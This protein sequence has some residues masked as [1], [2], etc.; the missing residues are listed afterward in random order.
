MLPSPVSSARR[1]TYRRNAATSRRK[2]NLFDVLYSRARVTNLGFL[3][4]AVV[5]TISLLYN[6]RYL[7][8]ARQPKHTDSSVLLSTVSR[9]VTHLRLNHL[10]I[11][12]GHAIWKGTDPELRLREDQWVLEP[13]QRGGGRISTFFAHIYRGA[14]LVR[15]DVNALLVFSGGQTRSASTTTEAE[16]YMRLALAADV[17]QTGSSTFKR[18]TTEDHALDSFQNFLFSIT[19]FHE[20]TGRYPTKITIIG[21]EF[22]RARFTDL[23]RRALRWPM[24]KF[25]YIGVDL[26]VDHHPIAE[27]GEVNGYL[28][29]SRDLYGCHSV[30]L[31]KRRQRNLHARFH[32]YYQSSPALRELLD[33]C[34]SS[35]TS[36]KGEDE[37]FMGGLPWDHA[38]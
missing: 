35:S 12:P 1:G 32:S 5:T 11:V 14:E 3:L 38:Y 10:I 33:W 34:P 17:F 2:F 4:L 9:D 18:A 28:P 36:A 24:E 27:T 13:Y 31:S 7:S 23:H 37:L 25:Q 20:Y 6:L 29:Y 8:R 15:E 16:S 30:L 26:D 21:Y 22:K 19:R